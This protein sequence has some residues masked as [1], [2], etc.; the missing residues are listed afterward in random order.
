MKDLYWNIRK[1]IRTI[2]II[3]DETYIP[4]QLVKPFNGKKEDPFLGETYIVTRWWPDNG[5]KFRKIS[6][7]SPLNVLVSALDTNAANHLPHAKE[8]RSFFVEELPGIK[9][10][11]TFIPPNVSSFYAALK[12]GK[13]SAFHIACHTDY[14]SNMEFCEICLDDGR[15]SSASISG[16]YTRFGEEA[17]LFFLDTCSIAR[18]ESGYGPTGASGFIPAL[19]K[20]QVRAVVCTHWDISDHK[21]PLFTRAFYTQLV[22][23]KNIGDAFQ[24]ARLNIKDKTDPT[25]LSYTLFGDPWGQINILAQQKELP[26]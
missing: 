22:S 11:V 2:V 14:D 24:F 8:E 10:I 16:E 15:V 9:V 26:E 17:S 21:A 12:Q 20:A 19:L 25:W 1:K 13:F 23:G 6:G 7:I 4:W 5:V 3:S 18:P